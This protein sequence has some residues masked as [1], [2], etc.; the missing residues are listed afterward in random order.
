MAFPYRVC[1]GLQD[2]GSWCG[3]SRH[4]QGDVTNADWVTVGGGD[5]F[6][7]AQDP[8]DPDIVYVESQG[9]N[10]SRLNVATGERTQLPKPGWRPRYPL[11]I[12]VST[13]ATG[14][15]TPDITGAETHCTIVAL[16]ESPMRPGLLYAGTDDGNVWLSRNDG[17]AWES[18]TGRFP[19]TPAGTWVSRIEPSR[20]DTATFYVTF[21][22][23][24]TND[25]TP[26]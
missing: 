4:R 7:T 20:F 25:F 21:D 14:A 12:G 6:Y 13:R 26:Y 5:G 2:N 8:T 1:G 10:M 22:G 9:G 11:K 24:R 23:H 17:G 18:L 19:G 3:P 15:I 16:A